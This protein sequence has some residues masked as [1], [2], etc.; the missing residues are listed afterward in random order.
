V[1]TLYMKLILT[2]ILRVNKLFGVHKGLVLRRSHFPGKVG[3][4]EW[5]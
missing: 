3:V 4:N 2:S 1:V 5:A